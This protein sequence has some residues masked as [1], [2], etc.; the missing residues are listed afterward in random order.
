MSTC[1]LVAV[2]TVCS[3]LLS[4]VHAAA[5]DDALDYQRHVRPILEQRCFPCHAETKSKKGLRLDSLAA[6]LRGGA[7]G[8]AIVFGDSANSLLIRRVTS[9]D[10][11]RVMPK[12]G[13]RLT[14]R[15][16]AALEAWVDRRAADLERAAAAMRSSEQRYDMALSPPPITSADDG[17][18]IDIVL[19]QYFAQHA[20]DPSSLVS[21]RVFARRAF[22]DTVGMLPA[23]QELEAFLHDPDPDRRARLV[24]RLLADKRRYAEHWMTFWNDAL[25]NDYAGTGYIDGGRAQITQWLF[26]AL[27][28]N[29][30]YDRFVAELV[31][32]PSAASAGFT[33]GIL[34]RGVVNASQTRP[35]QA[36]QN[37]SQVFLGL[38]IK[39]ASCHDSFINEWTLREAYSLAAVFADRPLEMHR[40][41]EPLGVTATPAFLYPEL[42]AIDADASGPQRLAQLAGKL[43]SPDNGRFTRTIVNRLW[44]RL[45]GRGLIEPVDE[46]DNPAWSPALLDL[47]ASDL[48]AHGYDLKRTM[49]LILTSRAYQ[50]PSVDDCDQLNA[51]FRFTGP[52]V[53]RMSAEQ[54]V[55]AVRS[56]T[57]VWP[58]TPKAIVRIPDEDAEAGSQAA[59]WIW[60]ESTAARHADN[61]A[62]L[63]RAAIDLTA[64][65]SAAFAVITCDNV[66]A[67]YV[68]G[69]QL[70]S[71]CDWATVET[72]DL[73]PHLRVGRNVIAVEARNGPG[74]TANP[75]GLIFSAQ[76]Q[77]DSQDAVNMLSSSTAWRCSHAPVEGWWAREFDASSW[78][79]AEELGALDAEPWR[80]GDRFAAASSFTH[81]PVRAV[82]LTADALMSALGRPNRGLRRQRHRHPVPELSSRRRPA[83]PRRSTASPDL[84]RPLGLARHP[85]LPERSDTASTLGCALPANERRRDTCGSLPPRSSSPPVGIRWAGV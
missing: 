68:N 76:A 53:R 2:W 64:M 77:Y 27:Y 78:D 70:G 21:D 35:M 69:K 43:T 1:R 4:T 20:E 58:L 11:R 38:N 41:D 24:R 5:A 84:D 51:N 45:M 82:Y 36:A 63:F 8:P 55:D 85:A 25:R 66:Y 74:G 75:A 14:Q 32:P 50:M 17:N 80:I 13:P 71:D 39:C 57:G 12:K 67:L 10:P 60:D 54:F 6:V 52:R 9:S 26:T 34:W 31:N 16:I 79:Y 19:A 23:M 49:E 73:M 28:S 56:L 72:Y 59:K 22:L 46:L 33:K 81:R 65:P 40:C 48:I 61:N 7:S 15:E 62:V 3:S 18:P 42:G 83:R 37:V 44:A 29:M 47:L 30:P